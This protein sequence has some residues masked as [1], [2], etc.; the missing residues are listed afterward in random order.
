MTY[1]ID[2]LRKKQIE[3]RKS[4]LPEIIENGKQNG[5]VRPYILPYRNCWSNFFPAIQNDLRHY[6]SANNI[7]PHT[8]IHNMMS[9]WVVCSNMYWPFNNS[10]GFQILSAFLSNRL[11]VDIK[12][13]ES[14][15]LEYE[16]EGMSPGELLGEDSGQRGSG[17]TSPDLAIIFKT[18]DN[19]KGILLIESKFTEHSFY[20]CSG[21]GKTKPGKPV[22][23]DNGRCLNT[24]GLLNSNFKNCHLLVW[25]RKYWDLLRSEINS[26]LFS[27]LKKCPMTNSCYQMFRQQA[28]AKAYKKRYD[29]VI[30]CV[31]TDSRNEALTNSCK[32]VG[33]KPFPD[34]WRELFPNMGFGWFSHNDWHQYVKENGS[35]R[36]RDWLKYIGERYLSDN[37]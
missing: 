11:V 36:Y 14:M 29:I 6:I 23:P 1:L 18:T 5:V 17:Q 8:G 31:A 28:L 21:Y 22:N 4:N 3:W 20:G 25:N 19:K 34:G 33:L 30:S 7:Q 10:D 37:R 35:S 32:S 26:N 27:R 24:K 16:E 13:I 15:E 12:H 2:N 9:S